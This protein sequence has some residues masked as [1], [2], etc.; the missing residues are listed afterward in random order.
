MKARTVL[1]MMVLLLP[2]LAWGQEKAV[3]ESG[4]AVILNPDGTWEY[5]EYTN[6]APLHFEQ[7]SGEEFRATMPTRPVTM[8][9]LGKLDDYYNYEF[10]NAQSLM[11]SVQLYTYDKKPLG[12]GY[13]KK[14]SKPG[15]GLFSRLRD[16]E[17]HKMVIDVHYLPNQEGSSVFLISK[18]KKFGSWETKKTL[19]NERK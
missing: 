7:M 4:R 15:Q 12:H 5:W 1:L 9:V 17:K 3:T 19:Q 14:E 10:S 18:V 16:G 11:W 8:R 6:S 13:V 2:T